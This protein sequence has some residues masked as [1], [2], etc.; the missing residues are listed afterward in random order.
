MNHDHVHST[1]A[2][3]KTANIKFASFFVKLSNKISANIP[4]YTVS[5][6]FS[7]IHISHHIS[8]LTSLFSAVN[9]PL[10]NTFLSHV[11]IFQ[12]SQICGPWV[13][14]D[15]LQSTHTVA[16]YGTINQTFDADVW[17]NYLQQNDL[18]AHIKIG[19]IQLALLKSINVIV[20]KGE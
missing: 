8:H 18:I 7:D 20:P 3:L 12:K 10:S 11:A 4:S 5:S 17:I 15:S 13:N 9:N 1:T 6:L 2:K 14:N 19:G 16:K